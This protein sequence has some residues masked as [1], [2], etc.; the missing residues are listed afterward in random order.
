M[1]SAS[2]AANAIQW[3]A[4][5]GLAWCAPSARE[6][7]GQPETELPLWPTDQMMATASIS[8]TG[9][10]SHS[11][12][13]PTGV[14]AV[15]W[16]WSP[17]ISLVAVITAGTG[18]PPH[19]PHGHRA[20]AG[21]CAGPGR[22]LRPAAGAF[23]GRGHQDPADSASFTGRGRELAQLMGTLAGMAANGG[24]VGI[25]AIGGMDAGVGKTTFAVHAA[26]R[27]A[28]SF[29]DGQ[30]FLPLHA[31]TAGLRPVEPTDVLASLLLTTG[32]PAAQIPPGLEARAAR[33]RDQVAGKKILLLLDDAADHDQV[34]PLV[35]GTAETLV[36]VTSR[37]RLTAPEEA[38]VIS[39]DTLP[40][41]R[42]L[43]CWPGSRPAPGCAP[44]I[45]PWLRSPG[46]ARTC[47]WRSGC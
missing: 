21:R 8:T 32:L 39:L 42:L 29:P 17:K 44:G 40:P 12:A 36:L 35:L 47:R 4:Q 11:A 43:F 27:L 46:C 3:L 19:H 30:F 6:P 9:F 14:L 22:Q 33:S 26:H 34:R 31:R 7:R 38:A 15:S 37:R 13:T 16:Y 10:G 1:D 23:Q 41:W 24:V 45:W 28:A 20:A 25:H 2:P 18:H 5:V